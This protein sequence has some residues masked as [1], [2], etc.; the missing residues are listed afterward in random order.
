VQFSA[1]DKNGVRSNKLM[2]VASMLMDGGLS[3]LVYKGLQKL[4]G[5]K[6]HDK[7]ADVYSKG[8]YKDLNE[9]EQQQRKGQKPAYQPEH[10]QER[11]YNRSGARR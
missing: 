7:N 4:F 2:F 8:H 9:Y 11:S 6:E 10:Q 3:F 1:T 5:Q